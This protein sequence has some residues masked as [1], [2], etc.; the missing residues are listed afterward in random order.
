MKLENAKTIAKLL[1]KN[2]LRCGVIKGNGTTVPINP[3]KFP[4]YFVNEPAWVGYDKG[5]VCPYI[6]YEHELGKKIADVLKIENITFEWSRKTADGI[7]IVDTYKR[8]NGTCSK[9]GAYN[10]NRQFRCGGD[11]CGVLWDYIEGG[12]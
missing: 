2:K 3:S 1:R 8:K 10:H 9:C 6:Y 7:K 4:V 5:H 11:W 12:D